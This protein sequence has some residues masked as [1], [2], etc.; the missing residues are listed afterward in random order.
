M[1]RKVIMAVL[2]VIFLCLTAGPSYTSDKDDYQVIKKAV[3]ENPKIQ[4]AG[5]AKWLKVLIVDKA[6]GKEKVK[7]TLPLSL[8]EIFARCAGKE[9][10]KMDGKNQNL[11]VEQLIEQLKKAGS[12]SIV[13]ID[14]EEATIKVWL[15]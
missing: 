6:T 3:Q 15:E 2:M 13:E 8:V 7:V 4:P 5:E 11:N 9:E 12:M 10:I 14:D 1:N